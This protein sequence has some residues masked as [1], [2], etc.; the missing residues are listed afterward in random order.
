MMSGGKTPRVCSGWMRQ[1]RPSRM[2]PEG[3][4]FVPIRGGKRR[5]P[6][7]QMSPREIPAASHCHGELMINLVR[8]GKTAE[9]NEV[10]L[11]MVTDSSRRSECLKITLQASSV[12]G[13]FTKTVRRA[14]RLL[15]ISIS[16]AAEVIIGSLGREPR[17]ISCKLGHSVGRAEIGR[18]HV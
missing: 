4:Q 15:A 10:S 11:S 12:S 3:H 6:A 5:P 13:E 2:L 18:A 16:E 17:R 7:S 9:G 8:F 14:F 1:V